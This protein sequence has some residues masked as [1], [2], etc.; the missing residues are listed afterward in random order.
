MITPE[1]ARQ[2][3][4][5]IEQLSISLDDETALE[6]V[7]LF[8][9]WNSTKSYQINDRIKFDN[10]LY[11]CVQAHTAQ[12]DWIPP[13]TPALWT[14]VSIEEWPEWVQP[15]GAQN[16]Y[17]TGDKVSHNNLHWISTIDSNVWEPG[18]YGWEQ[19]A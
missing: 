17:Q 2:L 9:E 14:R 19:Q 12:A 8:P 6:A 15:T 1:H 7:E 16:A 4:R 13:L 5:L 3:R 18:I 10:I 11:K